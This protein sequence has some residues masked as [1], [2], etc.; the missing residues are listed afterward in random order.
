MIK[1]ISKKNKLQTASRGKDKN[2]IVL[3]RFVDAPKVIMMKDLKTSAHVPR[4]LASK[5][6]SPKSN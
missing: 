5:C 6:L 4:T 1:D 3:V 2:I